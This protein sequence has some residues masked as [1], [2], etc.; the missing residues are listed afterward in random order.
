MRSL[1][2]PFECA[3]SKKKDSKNDWQVYTVLQTDLYIVCD[4]SKLDDRGC[5][6]APDRL[7]EIISAKNAKRGTKEKFEIYPEHGVREYWIVNPNDEN[8]THYSLRSALCKPRPPSHQFTSFLIKS[9]RIRG[10]RPF[11]ALHF[12][13]CTLQAQGRHP[14]N[15]HHS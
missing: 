13:L 8:V 3:F 9:L 1:P 11:S 5:L 12:A 15:L 7:I 10:L 6:G 4:L 2:C 14:L